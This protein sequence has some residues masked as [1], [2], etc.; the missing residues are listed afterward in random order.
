MS[1][2]DN[3]VTARRTTRS[4]RHESRAARRMSIHQDRS[5]PGWDTWRDRVIVSRVVAGVAIIVILHRVTARTSVVPLETTPQIVGDTNVMTRRI[6]IASK[7]IDD[8]FL[9]SMHVEGRAGVGPIEIFE[10]SR[11]SSAS[12]TQISRAGSDSEVIGIASLRVWWARVSVSRHDQS[13]PSRSARAA[14]A[15]A[16]SS[17]WTRTSNPP[18]NR[19]QQVVYLVDS[20]CL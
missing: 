9:N 6:G 7:N 14:R 16:G 1:Q 5:L 13:L 20:S 19:M 10:C 4:E 17:G 8:S 15:K 3:N 12:R 2:R 18:V 11:R